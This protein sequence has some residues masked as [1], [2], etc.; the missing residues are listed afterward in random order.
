[1]LDRAERVAKSV[2]L[3]D[4]RYVDLLRR[5]DRKQRNQRILA[6]SVGIAMFVAS[7]A[8]VTSIGSL[9]RT[10]RPVTGPA[11]SGPTVD[12]VWAFVGL[13]PEGAEPSGPEHG[14]LVAGVQQLHI[15][16]AFVYADGRVI[17]WGEDTSSQEPGPY[18]YGEQ[19][20]TP[21]G[22]QTLL[23]DL[24]R[25]GLFDRDLHVD[26]T[27]L[28]TPNPLSAFVRDGGRFL[29]VSHDGEGPPPTREQATALERVD[30]LLTDP[31][32]LVPASAWADRTMRPYVPNRYAICTDLHGLPAA[33]ADLLR[34][35]LRTFDGVA[36]WEGR[37]PDCY[38][39]TTEG[40]RALDRI[41][42]DAGFT[43][44]RA[45]V[46]TLGATYELE[47]PERS[48]DLRSRSVVSFYPVLPHGAI[49]IYRLA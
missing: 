22:V 20:L 41:L 11:V 5:R 49:A 8:V 16:G 39:A 36:W 18:G 32:S 33:A 24:R 1:M 46:R 37:G 6:G 45:D 43:A 26:E 31:E 13:P 38:D 25:T 40:A 47:S 23:S 21:E 15:G 4:D 12:P 19:L 44:A 35:R 17:S 3:P 9:D 7:I 10:G 2:A 28:F 30:L 42:T 14:E 48:S 27:H 34:G 29:R